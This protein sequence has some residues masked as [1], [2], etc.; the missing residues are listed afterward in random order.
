MLSIKNL[1]LKYPNA[2]HKIF[3]GLDLTIE[4]KEKVLLLGPSGAG[5]STLLNVLS[6][7]VPDLIELPMKYD[8]LNID[9]HCA[10]IFQDP[11]TQFCMPKVK[12]ELAFILENRQVPRSD[13]DEA[14]D[15]ALRSVDLTVNPN[16]YVNKL[17]GGMKQKLAIAETLLQ[18]ADTLFLDEPT[19][20]L[21]TK[22]TTELWNKI[23]RFWKNQTVVIVEHKVEHIWEHIDR[24]ILLNYNAEIIA[25]DTPEKILQ[26]H[27][28]L[29]SE[30][31]VWHPRAWEHAPE[32]VLTANN[33]ATKEYAFTYKNGVIRRNKQA[34][35]SIEDFSVAPGEWIT[36]TG[37][38][39]AG[40]TTLFESMMQLISYDG[41]MYYHQQPIRKIK[42]AAKHMYLVYQNPELQFIT[43]SVYDEIHIQFS[44]K[45]KEQAKLKT[46]QM[47]ELL[48]LSQV[49]AQHPFE[50][51]IGQ[52]RR[53]S[54]ATALSSPADIIMLDEPTFG[55]DSHNTF[56]LIQLFQERVQNGQTIIMITHDPEIISRYPTRRFHVEDQTLLEVR[57]TGED[58]V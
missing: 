42:E 7:I 19:A 14:I 57:K 54:V 51:S 30:Y 47:L 31:G 53:L 15:K 44:Q 56:N 18:Q 58:N 43:Q 8:R 55:L 34:L 3:D 41:K 45:D 22:S 48:N 5:K 32:P 52:K 11:D 36:I 37:Q 16:Q 23:K 29:L 9:K 39:G 12:E 46:E 33:D 13:M 21:D 2:D 17:S 35:I 26:H 25:D 6:G 20:M 10:M 50:L 28:R 49:R 38:N 4:D 40:K 27:E 24:V 1:R